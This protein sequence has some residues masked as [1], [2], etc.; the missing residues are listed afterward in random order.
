[1]IREINK[2]LSHQQ[3]GLIL[4]FAAIPIIAYLKWVHDDHVAL[5]AVASI[6]LAMG[7]IELGK[8]NE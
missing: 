3:K 8:K 1:M 2:S 5:G 6:L 7:V 4:F